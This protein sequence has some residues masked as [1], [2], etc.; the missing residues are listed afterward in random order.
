MWWLLWIALGATAL[1]GLHR[2]ALWAERRGWIYY[3]QHR[4]PAGAAGLAMLEATSL[5][6]PAVEH[7]IEETRGVRARAEQDDQGEGR[8]GL[9]G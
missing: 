7:V 6:D 2:L 5:I 4:A 3:R 1:Y 8:P 9:G